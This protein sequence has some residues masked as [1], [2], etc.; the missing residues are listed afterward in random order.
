MRSLRPVKP[1][2][3]A[4]GRWSGCRHFLSARYQAADLEAVPEAE[5]ILAPDGEIVSSGIGPL[6]WGA[7]PSGGQVFAP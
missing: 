1:T 7:P 5:L 4:S 6:V 3:L 2:A